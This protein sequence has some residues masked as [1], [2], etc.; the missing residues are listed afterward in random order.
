MVRALREHIEHHPH[1]VGFQVCFDPSHYSFRAFDIK[2]LEV[3]PEGDERLEKE[4]LCT[5][6]ADLHD[7]N[8]LGRWFL[9]RFSGHRVVGRDLELVVSHVWK[10]TFAEDFAP[11][12]AQAEAV[13]LQQRI[14]VI[15]D[16]VR[17]KGVRL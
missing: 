17:P 10:I 14:P 4:A 16:G 13:D 12:N 6:L 2:G 11:R 7:D 9:E 3:S 5:L 1:L 15:P 8:P